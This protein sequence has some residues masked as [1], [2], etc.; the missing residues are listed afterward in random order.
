MGLG[1]LGEIDCRRSRVG[2]ALRALIEKLQVHVTRGQR[3]VAM[4]DDSVVQD[5][6]NKNTATLDRIREVVSLRARTLDDSIG[7]RLLFLAHPSHSLTD[8]FEGACDN[9]AGGGEMFIFE[10][11][12]ELELRGARSAFRVAYWPTRAPDAVIKAR[13]PKVSTFAT[14]SSGSISGAAA[15]GDIRDTQIARDT[16]DTRIDEI[17]ERI[18]AL[19]FT[20]DEVLRRSEL[21]ERIGLL[22]ATAL[23][24]LLML[25]IFLGAWLISRLS[26]R[27][28][29][30]TSISRGLPSLRDPLSPPRSVDGTGTREPP[31]QSGESAPGVAAPAMG[32]KPISR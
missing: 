1:F 10:T 8:S 32:P 9:V 21:A 31:S 6:L 19:E 11:A 4:P 17:V 12:A 18:G 26:A 27:L 29:Q 30:L 3:F 13:A 14:G 22:V 15:L 28:D 2:A 5:F 23:T 24:I 7:Q 20:C 25:E 16:R